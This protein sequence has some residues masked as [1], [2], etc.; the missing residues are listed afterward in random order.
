MPFPCLSL[1]TRKNGFEFLVES[2]AYAMALVPISDARVFGGRPVS[3]DL[4]QNKSSAQSELPKDRN[5]KIVRVVLL[6]QTSNMAK[7]DTIDEDV[8]GPATRYLV[9]IADQNPNFLLSKIT[10]RHLKSLV[11]VWHRFKEALSPNISVEVHQ[12]AIPQ[13]ELQY[14][15]TCR[16][17]ASL[18]P[19]D[20]IS[21]KLALA[22][23][24]MPSLKTFHINFD[25]AF[26]CGPWNTLLQSL[27]SLPCLE[28]LD[29][30]AQ[31]RY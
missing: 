2:L 6:L 27:N 20:N 5:D 26:Y 22:L 10:L 7:L 14:P 9:P 18:E 11:C 12:I 29:I 13:P 16:E 1:V 31:W 24:S 4:E 21:E 25:P 23:P 3:H 30:D 8:L 19:P 28:I 15:G 17:I